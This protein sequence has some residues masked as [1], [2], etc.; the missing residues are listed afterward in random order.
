VKV[1]LRKKIAFV[2]CNK[3]H[4]HSSFT[5]N[6]D[7]LTGKFFLSDARQVEFL[8][9]EL[10]D[11][12]P[13]LVIVFE[14]ENFTQFAHVISRYLTVGYLLEPLPFDGNYGD[15]KLNQNF[16]K[17]EKLSLE[18][19]TTYK[20]LIAGNSIFSRAY[21]SLFNIWQYRTL[22]VN[23]SLFRARFEP[24]L[25]NYNQV[26]FAGEV[27]EYTKKY[28]EEVNTKR[29]VISSLEVENDQIE[30]KNFPIGL[31]LHSFKFVDFEHEALI[32]MAN[33]RLLLSQVLSPK[34][35]FKN[36]FSHLEFDSPGNLMELLEDISSY[37]DSY[38]AIRRYGFHATSRY[39]ASK[40]WSDFMLDVELSR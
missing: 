22:P 27:N 16:E 9:H 11:F 31:N 26:L 24:D 35:N 19:S 4:A 10:E 32:H 14:P 23:D 18:I 37:P 15:S 28:I 30:I 7:A 2:S 1:S 5:G 8:E 29:P 21:E 20:Y 13:D 25:S 39:K 6:S 12:Q 3:T 36:G 40:M 17:L 38:E 34:L 33:G